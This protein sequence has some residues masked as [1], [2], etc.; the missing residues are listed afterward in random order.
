MQL[1]V[2]VHQ[3]LVVL[4]QMV[5]F[6]CITLAGCTKAILVLLEIL[7]RVVMV[8]VHLRETEAL[9]D[10]MAVVVVVVVEATAAQMVVMVVM[11]AELVLVEEEEVKPLRAEQVAMEV[12]VLQAIQISIFSCKLPPYLLMQECLEVTEEVEVAAVVAP[13]IHPRK[14]LEEQA[15]LGFLPS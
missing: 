14:D 8:L 12:M 15:H 13:Q 7:K 4:V 1:L 10:P 3:I 11:P 2:V 5:I 9:Q 6:I